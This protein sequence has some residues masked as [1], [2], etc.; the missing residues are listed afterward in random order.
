MRRSPRGAARPPGAAR[1]GSKAEAHGKDGKDQRSFAFAQAFARGNYS[2][3]PCG[4]TAPERTGANS[5][6]KST[7]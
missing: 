2:A 6:T 4:L 5:C 3:Q 1:G 7:S